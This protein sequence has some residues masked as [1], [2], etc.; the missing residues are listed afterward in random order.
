MLYAY[1]SG[2]VATSRD[3]STRP[4][5]TA[6]AAMASQ[7]DH[8]DDDFEDDGPSRSSSMPVA[9]AV[10]ESATPASASASASAAGTDGSAG[11][12]ADVEMP[13][14]SSD[15]LELGPK[16]GG[17][18]FAV[19]F[20]ARWRGRTVAAKIQVDPSASE[21]L[22]RELIDEVQV[23]LSVRHPNIV[24]CLGGCTRPPRMCV[25]M[26]LCGD[27]LFSVLHTPTAC[28]WSGAASALETA[29]LVDWAADAASAIAHLHSRSPRVV[30]RDIKSHNLLLDKEGHLKLCDF[31][32]V[33]NRDPTAGTPQYMAPELLRGAAYSYKVDAYAFGILLWE[34]RY[35][36]TLRI[37]SAR[38]FVSSDG[39]TRPVR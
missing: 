12:T 6:N 14:I 8:Y 18:G 38:S 34:V 33:S 19:V 13:F 3:R 9:R 31:G 35:P 37:H 21:R 29:R 36:P 4:R 17:G 20:K 22:R 11:S 23:M 30:H 27:S 2:R 24:E 5:Q 16:L 32:L 10:G 28:R 1:G 15:E 39:V 7:E 25:V 26:E